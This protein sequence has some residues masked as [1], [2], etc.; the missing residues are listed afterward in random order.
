MN[1]TIDR[2]PMSRGVTQLMYVGDVETA[3][4]KILEWTVAMLAGGYALGTKK[5]SRRKIAGVVALVALYKA[6]K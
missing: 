6:I 3:E 5:K 2:R 1:V 4:P